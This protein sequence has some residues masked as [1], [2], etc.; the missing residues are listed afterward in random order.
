[1]SATTQPN[2]YVDEYT[3]PATTQDP[4]SQ[5]SAGTDQSDPQ[6][7]FQNNEPIVTTQENS[8]VASQEDTGSSKVQEEDLE[9]QNIFF[10]LDAEDGSDD[11]KE[12]FLNQLQEV[13]WNDFLNSDVELL[14][15]D[16]ETVSFNKLNTVAEE[17]TDENSKEQAKDKVVEYLEKLIPDLE[18][19]ML[20][21]ALDLKADLFVERISGMKDLYTENQEKMDLVLKAESLMFEDKWRSAAQILNS[22]QE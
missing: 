8:T 22:I 14:L 1:M 5:V 15:T 4:S 9:A 6:A 20:E 10:M 12:R 13:I 21:K 7:S 2:S 18:E 3:P 17:A 11:L 16:E 19:I